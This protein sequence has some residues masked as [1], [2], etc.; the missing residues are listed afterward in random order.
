MQAEDSTVGPQGTGAGV[1]VV[2]RVVL[3]DSSEEDA[4]E[5]C[6]AVRMALPK[7][8]IARRTATREQTDSFG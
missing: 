5:W 2:G 7:S 1:L 6:E 3:T 4:E 8:T